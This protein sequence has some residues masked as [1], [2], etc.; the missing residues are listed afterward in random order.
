MRVVVLGAAGEVGKA[1]TADLAR[2]PEIDHIVAADLAPG[3]LEELA[4]GIDRMSAARLDLHD[5]QQAL[6]LLD[7]CDLL[8]NCTSF[9]LFDDVIDLAVT[10]GVDYADLISEPSDEQARAVEAAGI[11]AISGLGL[12]PGLSNVLVAHAAGE[13]GEIEEVNIAW[14]SF[15]TIA[16]SRGLLDT[17]LWELSEGCR[18]REYFQGG[19][20]HRAGPLEGSRMVDFASPGGPQRVYFVPHPEVRTLPRHFPT[21]TYCAVRGTWRPELMEDVNVLNRYGLL[22]EETLETTK[23]VV[24]DR[25]GGQRDA[26][27]WMLFLNVE[28]IGFRDG[29]AVRRVYDVSHPMGWNQE[30]IGRMTGICAAVGAQLLARH[31]RGQAGFIDP[32]AY[33]DPQEFLVELERRGTVS[34]TCSENIVNGWTLKRST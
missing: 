16:P 8:V 34:V 19:R 27:P 26:A 13:L 33:F 30:A 22:G 4:G 12:T 11:T 32:E 31:G 14:M 9:A 5:R 3:P 20:F 25:F 1:L 10:A 24:W 29:E 28:V 23:S 7:G 21:L 18:T 17:I 6:G 15:R 2:C